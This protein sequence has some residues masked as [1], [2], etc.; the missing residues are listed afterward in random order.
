[1]EDHVDYELPF[2]V[3]G[4]IAHRLRVRSQLEEIFDYRRKAIEQIFGAR[5]GAAAAR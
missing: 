2:G 4:R 3:F 5:T 1:M